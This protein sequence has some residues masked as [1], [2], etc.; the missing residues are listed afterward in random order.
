MCRIILNHQNQEF[1][2]NEL[3]ESYRQNPDGTGL[4]YWD[5]KVKEPIIKKWAKNTKFEEIWKEVSKLHRNKNYTNVNIHFRFGTSGGIGPNQTHPIEMD[6]K[7]F[8]MHNG[9]CQE[10]VWNNDKFSDTQCMAYWLNELLRMKHIKKLSELAEDE[11]LFS[12]IEYKFSG[13]K[14]VLMQE[15]KVLIFNEDLGE[16]KNG[17]WRSWK[18]YQYY[19]YESMIKVQDYLIQYKD[20]EKNNKVE[21]HVIYYCSNETA[22]IRR[23]EIAK[24]NCE[25]ISIEP[26]E[27]YNFN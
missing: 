12:Y 26:I 15:D 14:V 18:E 17:I 11:M 13:S 19:G 5:D 8:M 23:F 3:E 4:Y 2:K 6:N 16:W 27:E 25:I 1:V 22:A 10:F 20:K 24:P 9:V 21:T 7:I